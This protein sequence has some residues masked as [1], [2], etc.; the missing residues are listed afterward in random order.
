MKK[1]F[2]LFFMTALIATSGCISGGEKMNLKGKKVLMVI[3]PDNFRDEEY[4]HTR[5]VLESYGASV[6]TASSKTGE[7]TGMLGGTAVADIVLSQANPSEYDAVVFVG[8]SG[9]SAYFNDET[10]LGL[11]QRAYEDGKV[12]AAICIAPNILAQAGLLEGKKATAY[13]SVK[14]DLTEK[15][16]VWSNESV[17]RDG[18][19][20][21][22]NGPAA[23][24]RFGEE[25]AKL[26]SE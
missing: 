23:A 7:I 1:L 3:A 2:I 14:S 12:V 9:A 22:A 19:I 11:A 13:E 10:A 21:T 15:G 5:E 17:V 25:I 8:G 20:I 16:A 18:R 24:R 4:F 26:L 6:T